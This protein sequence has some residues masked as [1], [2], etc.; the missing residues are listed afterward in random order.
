M[1]L[2]LVLTFVWGAA[3]AQDSTDRRLRVA[4]LDFEVIQL[5]G[6]GDAGLLGRAMAREFE[7]S[8]VQ[9]RRFTVV[10]RLD[11]EQVLD[12]LALGATGIV[13]PVQARVFGE[14]LEADLLITGS[15]TAFSA[16]SYSLTARFI[17]VATGELRSAETLHATSTSELP[18]VAQ[19]FVE[20]ALALYPIR[21]IV[22]AIE[23]AGALVDIGSSIGLSGTGATGTI[24][25]QRVVAG[26]TIP[27]RVG[28]F[29]VL[30]VYDHAAMI[31]VDTTPGETL[32]LGDQVRVDVHTEAPTPAEDV[33]IV[34]VLHV[35][36]TPRGA[37][38]AVDGQVVGA[39]GPIEL[40]LAPGPT[41][42]IVTADG[43][44]SEERSVVVSQDRTT[45][46]EIALEPTARASEPPPPSA[47]LP[48][49]PARLSLWRSADRY[50]A[51]LLNMT[52]HQRTADG[53]LMRDWT[54]NIPDSVEFEIHA[55][56]VLPNGDLGV[57]FRLADVAIGTTV[58]VEMLDPH[59]SWNMDTYLYLYDAIAGKVI[60][61]NDDAPDT[62]RSEIVFTI[63]PGVRYAIVASS[64]GGSD[65]GPVVLN[66][67]GR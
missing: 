25:R 15:I 61:D 5:A 26:R 46:V 53:V 34:G 14:L 9:S 2:L 20:R 56:S 51:D 54:L 12:E 37:T 35:T 10:A 7:G 49:P 11:L 3:L 60:A 22:F 23:D 47:T 30:E 50:G 62:N 59:R 31:E 44:V 43:Y 16:T 38:V 41:S 36:G 6:A 19:R 55:G 33:V 17:D 28:T 4:V 29:T 48:S 24:E 65:T 57:V 58:E 8:L 66:V 32:E 63:E 42:L 40:R 52:R 13:S 39:L 67:T 21:G 18:S 1:L 45:H 64:W 27:V